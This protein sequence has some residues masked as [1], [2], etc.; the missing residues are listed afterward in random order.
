MSALWRSAWDENEFNTFFLVFLSWAI[1]SS[2][3]YV[4]CC[5]YTLKLRIWIWIIALSFGGLFK[6]AEER[7]RPTPRLQTSCQDGLTLFPPHFQNPD[8]GDCQQKP[9]AN[10]LS[11]SQWV[12]MASGNGGDDGLWV[13]WSDWVEFLILW[14]R[15]L[16]EPSCLDTGIDLT[17]GI[18]GSQGHALGEN[19]VVGAWSSPTT[20]TIVSGEILKNTRQFQWNLKCWRKGFSYSKS[21]SI[22]LDDGVG[23]VTNEEKISPLLKAQ[24][25]F[26]CDRSF[27][28]YD[29][30]PEEG[31]SQCTSVKCQTP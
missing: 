21:S 29:G 5:L 26:V 13:A 10:G 16:A 11:D 3:C 27:A 30:L 6:S 12:I 14:P 25:F 17:D 7:C 24:Q 23:L 28:R 4:C 8:F 31:K 9:R 20:G 15:P 1:Y 19:A 22:S 2:F 18:W